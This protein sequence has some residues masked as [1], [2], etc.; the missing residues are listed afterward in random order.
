VPLAFEQHVGEDR[1]RVLALDDPLEELQFAQQIRLSDDQF[2]G[3]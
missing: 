2:H 3:G 1:N